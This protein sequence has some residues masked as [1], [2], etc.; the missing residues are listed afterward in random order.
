MRIKVGSSCRLRS[1]TP[2]LAA[3]LCVAEHDP[4]HTERTC[5]VDIERMVVDKGGLG[6]D[7]LVARQEVL[8][9][10]TLRLHHLHL[11]DDDPLERVPEQE[12]IT[13]LVTSVRIVGTNGTVWLEDWAPPW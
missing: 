5:G 12:S 7:E 13:D 1:R 3:L 2:F 4:V 8:E 11:A 6:R 9:N 10:L